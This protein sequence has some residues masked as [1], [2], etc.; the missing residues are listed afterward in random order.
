MA[1]VTV[2]ED[3]QLVMDFSDSYA[4]GVQVVIVPEGSDITSMD[5]LGRA[6]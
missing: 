6:R 2:T 3:R 5:D 4:T 1:G